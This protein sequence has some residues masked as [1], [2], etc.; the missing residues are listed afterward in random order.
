MA[1][2]F[3]LVHGAWHGAWC[4]A[5]VIGQLEAAGHR[6]YAVDLPAHGANHLDPALA[7]RRLYVD[8]VIRFIEEHHLKNII[9]A[10]HSLGGMT[11]AGVAQRIPEQI[12]RVVFVTALVIPHDSSP[13]DDVASIL[14]P[15]AAGHMHGLAEGAPS[16][17]L[18]EER[19]RSAF[20]QDGSRDLQDF[21]IA[22]LVP[23]PSAPF[24]ERA[25]SKD[26]YSS[27][28]PVSYVLC[29]QDLVFDD[30]KLWHRFIE[31]LNHPTVHRINSGHEVM[32]TQPLACAKTLARIAAE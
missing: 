21:V 15:A 11:I 2:T 25:P 29:E 17:T 13:A 12:K 27:A 18:A 4:W 5:G 14:T 31:R 32:F 1:E 30:A 6:A 7:T 26:F 19:F 22:A 23:E 9:L 24:S 10:G 8:S 3:V 16:I 28:V 20:I